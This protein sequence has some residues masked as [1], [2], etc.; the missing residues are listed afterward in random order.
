MAKKKPQKLKKSLFSSYLTT[1]LSI[2]M[3]LFLFGLLGLLIINAQRLSDYVMENIGVTLILRDDA[4][5]A[6]VMK[7]QKNLEM[8]SYIKSTRFVDKESAAVE[9]KKELGEDFV[10]FLGFN[11]LLS[12]IDV[13][14]F[15]GYA[16]PDS[17]AMLEKKL[18]ANP[19]IQEVYYQ[20]NLVKQ[21]NSNVKKISFILLA[22]C[23]LMFVIFTALINNTIRLSVYSKRFLINTMQ[24]VGATRSFIRWPFIAKSALHGIYGAI[25]ACFML[26]AIFFSYQKELKSFVDFQNPTALV[27]LVGGIFVIGILIT[28]I[29]TYFAIN[30]FLRLKFDQLFY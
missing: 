23:L 24:L 13:T 29:S 11:P 16:N 19:E 3:I 27:M 15:A 1:T 14:V 30:K 22:L 4:K 20:R 7:L 18:L 5:E 6:D 26:L 9:L 17:L 2:S 8:A 25:I 10:D 21:L 28:V 12:S